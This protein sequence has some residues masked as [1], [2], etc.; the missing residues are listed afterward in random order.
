MKKLFI[1]SL[2]LSVSLLKGVAQNSSSGPQFGAKTLTDQVEV[3]PLPNPA[4]NGVLNIGEGF[5]DI[6]T[7]IG[8]G[9]VMVNNSNPIGTT[10]WFQGNSGIFSAYDGAPTAY[11]GANF[12]NTTGT[13]TISNW[14]LTPE[15]TIHNGDQIKFYTRT[16]TGSS[17]PDRLQ[18]RLSIN[19]A[20]TD[21]G[22][23]ENSVGDFNI[24]LLDINPV[25][26]IGG[27]PDAWTQFTV[28][29]SGL[30][31]NESGR[32][33]FR[34]YVTNGGPSGANSNYFGIDRVEFTE[35][36]SVPVSDWALFIGIGLILVFAAIRFRKMC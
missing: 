7:L 33:G 1:I 34:Y 29:I 16:V 15:Q 9:W 3:K 11:I 32:F 21:V 36:E 28:T 22:S 14:L 23:N 30:S 2:I 27:F 25:L 10:G 31:G 5:D 26:V 13:G 4:I 24:L 19:G 6:T 8:N 12:N 20:G 18:V 35:S 17:F